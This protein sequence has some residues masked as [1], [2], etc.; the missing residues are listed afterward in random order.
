M[1]AFDGEAVR[2][3][4]DAGE[5]CGSRRRDEPLDFGAGERR[6]GEEREHSER[7]YREGQAHRFWDFLAGDI[8]SD[9]DAG[10]LGGG[11]R[12]SRV[13]PVQEASCVTGDD[14]ELGEAPL[15]VE[16]G[17]RKEQA[18]VAGRRALAVER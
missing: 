6:R 1:S 3:H 10:A 12:L 17:V 5:R 15:A 13:A 11:A 18:L 4:D 8:E 16:V 14:G 2:L 7:P 9:A